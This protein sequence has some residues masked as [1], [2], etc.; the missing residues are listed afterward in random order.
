MLDFIECVTRLK[1]ALLK[2]S[3]PGVDPCVELDIF[4]NEQF[5]NEFNNL[6]KQSANS[7]ESYESKREFYELLKQAF[8]KYQTH[9]EPWLYSRRLTTLQ[10]TVGK[11]FVESFRATEEAMQ[12]QVSEWRAEASLLFQSLESFNLS[13]VSETPYATHD[14]IIVRIAL[15]AKEHK[16]LGVESGGHSTIEVRQKNSMPLY[17]GFYVDR[18]PAKLSFR[19]RL[20]KRIGV[21]SPDKR[22]ADFVELEN[23]RLR[24]QCDVIRIPCSAGLDCSAA[25]EY[26]AKNKYKK[27]DEKTWQPKLDDYQF[28]SR[29][30]SSFVREA[31]MKAQGKN[32]LPYSGATILNLDTPMEVR[33]YAQQLRDKVLLQ[34]AEVIRGSN[35]VKDDKTHLIQAIHVL[36]EINCSRQYQVLVEA[37]IH[38]FTRIINFPSSVPS[39]FEDMEKLMLKLEQLQPQTPDLV[40]IKAAISGA[41]T[42]LTMRVQNIELTLI[43]VSIHT[44]THNLPGVKPPDMSSINTASS[45]LSYIDETLKSLKTE[46][47]TDEAKSHITQLETIRGELY[48]LQYF[49]RDAEGRHDIITQMAPYVLPNWTFN[50]IQPTM[51]NL[52]ELGVSS[53]SGVPSTPFHASERETKLELHRIINDKERDLPAKLTDVSKLINKQRPWWTWLLWWTDTKK[54]FVN[55]EN[56]GRLL[57]IMDAFLKGKITPSELGTKLAQTKNWLPTNKVDRWVEHIDGPHSYAQMGQL[58][59]QGAVTE[60]TSDSMTRDETMERQDD[61]SAPLQNQVPDELLD[62]EGHTP[63][64]N[65]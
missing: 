59:L 26:L 19:S 21:P 41:I 44:A 36:R 20:A 31:L 22:T 15:S 10:T 64:M 62:D 35:P 57:C 11:V 40:A 23:D 38:R 6:A 3:Q 14:E 37:I 16:V 25:Y 51:S 12:T 2:S 61:R 30:C 50:T 52:I 18:R 54:Q 34:R 60:I 56:R 58:G 9:P 4:F 53:L 55:L 65:R 24:Y 5:I 1:K 49:K 33:A 13:E 46:S 42:S 63:K 43:K 8:E 27:F 39:L 7:I 47:S 32:P 29:N 28:Y 48:D 45:M 17:F